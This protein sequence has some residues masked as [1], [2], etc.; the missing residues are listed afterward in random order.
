MTMT[1]KLHEHLNERIFLSLLS[2]WRWERRTSLPIISTG[3]VDH[4]AQM[5]L[6][7]ASIKL[8]IGNPDP[9]IMTDLMK[10]MATIQS[11]EFQV[12]KLLHANDTNIC[13]IC[14]IFPIMIWDMGFRS[15]MTFM[16]TTTITTMNF[17]MTFFTMTLP[18]PPL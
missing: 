12:P 15:L 10:N 14:F 5:T 3:T 17:T 11:L 7:G 4:V 8:D 2:W 18:S 16:A 9:I 1:N 13:V 6:V